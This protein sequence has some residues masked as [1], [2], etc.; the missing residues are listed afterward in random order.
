[1]LSDCWT[2][3]MMDHGRCRGCSTETNLDPVGLPGKGRR[4]LPLSV[5]M[6]ADTLVGVGSADP[7]H[8]RAGLRMPTSSKPA[9]PYHAG[10]NQEV[11]ASH[12]AARTT[13]SER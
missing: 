2:A 13:V 10:T 3:P 12:P 8:V 11:I 9:I 6:L 4:H 1:M 7:R 5:R